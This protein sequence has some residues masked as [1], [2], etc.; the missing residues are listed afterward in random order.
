MAPLRFTL[1]VLFLFFPTLLMA[2]SISGKATVNEEAVAGIKVFAYPLASRDFSGLPPFQGGPT[3]EEGLFEIEL[4]QG[5]YYLL[6][7]G[8]GRF[9]YYGRNPVSVPQEGLNNINLL[10]VP[11]NLPISGQTPFIESGVYGIVTNDGQPVAGAVIMVYTDLSSQLKGL[12][13][14]MSAPTAEDG[15]FELSLSP[16]TYYL[17]VRVRSGGSMAGPLRA[18][19]RFGYF[20]GNPVQ[21]EDGQ[22][23]PVHIPVIAVPEKVER[24]STSL[25]GN[26]TIS[27]QVVDDSGQ[28]LAGL[29]ALLYDDPSMLNRPLYVSQPTGEDGRFVLSFPSGGKYYLAAR[30]ELGGTP[31]PGELYG[32]YLGSDDHSIEIETGTAK[33]DIE[34]KVEEVY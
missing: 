12:G 19:D 7:R 24:Y 13:F 6:A 3:E 4:P 1:L 2:A 5:Q 27:G 34:I 25:F 18:G 16:G 14:G 20:P 32:R 8:E 28:P 23:A 30:N 29:R 33:E 31:A 9:T 26:T 10:M 21:I 11:D 15:Q 22:I 17:V